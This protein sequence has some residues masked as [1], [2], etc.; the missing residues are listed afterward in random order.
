MSEGLLKELRS[1][2]DKRKPR[3]LVVGDLMIDSYLW[4][5][6]GR[7]SPEAPVQVVDVTRET[8]EIGG[9]GN[10]AANLTALGAEAWMVSV[11]G[12]GAR[13]D[14]MER[15]LGAYGVDTS[16]VVIE[17]GRPVTEKTRVVAGN[18]Q[19]VRCDVETRADVTRDSEQKVLACVDTAVDAVDLIV[20]S[21]YGKG[22]LTPTLTQGII[23]RAAA[24]GVRVLCDPKGLDWSKYRGATAITPNRGEAVSVTG[25]DIVDDATLSE[26]GQK[27]LAD[28]ALSH[29][30]ITLSDEGMA[31]FH[32]DNC[33]RFPTEAREVY[34]VTG[35]GDTVIASLAFA[36][37]CGLELDDACRFA[38]FAA[39]VAVSKI[40]TAKVTLDEIEQTS[41]SKVRT[42]D[43]MAAIREQLRRQGRKVVFTNGCFDILHVG[44][45]KY[46]AQ[47]RAMGDVLIIGLNTDASVR[48]IKPGRPINTQDDRAYLL[49]AFSF[50]DYV[51]LFDEDTPQKLIE[52]VLPDVL[53]KGGD[54]EV[55]QIVG[56]DVVRESGGSVCTIPLVAGHST[57]SLIE[58]LRT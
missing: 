31:L 55:D 8:T 6:C 50:V 19:V 52:M 7:I 29:C 48:R 9:A 32:G 37:A 2:L 46:L 34:D 45:A 44:H 25:I 21:D 27:L 39:G 15:L 10:V 14:E 56:A 42:P 35:A 51:V 58:K 38:N 23:K 17:P 11:I 13:R 1:A 47:A 18:Q 30:L 43:Q 41:G 20:I 33:Q 16:A 5:R 40:G 49:G 4:G 53:V 36:L 3:V 57:T 26:A 12:D 24:A 28:Y 54:Y 22:V